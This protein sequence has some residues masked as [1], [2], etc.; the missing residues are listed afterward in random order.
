MTELLLSK[1]E[2]IDFRNLKANWR[3]RK[4]K[5]EIE[6]LTSE[7][8]SEIND[9]GS[10]FSDANAPIN[11]ISEIENLNSSL[12][13]KPLEE[14][15]EIKL[16][17]EQTTS[18]F[19]EFLKNVSLSTREDIEFILKKISDR[20]ERVQAL[21]T[22]L[23]TIDKTY[24]EAQNTS[25]KEL[26]DKIPVLKRISDEFSPQQEIAPQE[27]NIKPAEPSF[28]ND[29]PYVVS[30]HQ[31]S[32]N[33]I[34]TLNKKTSEPA[35]AIDELLVNNVDTDNTFFDEDGLPA[36]IKEETKTK[37][38]FT[39]EIVPTGLYGEDEKTKSTNE[40]DDFVGITLDELNAEPAIDSEKP[41]KKSEDIKYE[42]TAED[43]LSG[44][45]Q[46]L[47]GIKSAWYDLYEA[48]KEIL[49]SRL[50]EKGITEKADIEN[51]KGVFNGLSIVIPNEFTAE[52]NTK[53][54]KL[55]A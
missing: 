34:E 20:K 52:A 49:N 41:A 28:F 55:V 23:D 24:P 47:Y 33:L 46:S 25:S 35:L 32:E 50:Q 13:A 8:S 37:P 31:A 6:H 11:Y 9:A 53:M 12:E 51:Q 5:K 38:V 19:Q 2:M 21:Q 36:L 22:T 7:I 42:L 10:I 43:T 45:A 29:E 44:L 54:T 39:D 16:K 3:I 1:K 14:S 40:L 48:N 26:Y 18:K 30:I 15:Q 17:I 27:E 4:L